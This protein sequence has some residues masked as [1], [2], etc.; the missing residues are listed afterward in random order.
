M[1]YTT[2]LLDGLARLL[3]AAGVG[4][5]RPTGPYVTGETAITI[6]SMPSVPDR[7]ICLDA[8]PVEESAGLTDTTTGVQVWTRAGPDPRDVIALDDAAF[9]VL[10]GSGPHLWGVARVQLVYRQSAA[11]LGTDATHRHERTSNFY[12]RAH[13]AAPNL[14]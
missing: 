4:T 8:Y 13:R 10:Q 1:S 14:E 12:C 11:G 3:D 7:V 6:A 9:G 2:D 5:Y